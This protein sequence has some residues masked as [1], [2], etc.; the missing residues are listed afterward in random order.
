VFLVRC[1]DASLAEALHAT[2]EHEAFGEEWSA[3]FGEIMKP[4]HRHDVKL[5]L[6]APPVCEE[7]PTTL[8]PV[9][10]AS[11]S[12]SPNPN[13]NSNPTQPHPNQVRAA[14]ASL[15][16][17]LQ[18]ALTARLG[19]GSRLHEL[20]ALVSLPGAARQPVHPDTPMSSFE[21]V[22]EGE[23]KVSSSEC[24]TYQV[25]SST[26]HSLTARRGATSVNYA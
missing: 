3:R 24:A 14:L 12:A 17:A 10:N 7:A 5:G 18:P 11:A 25:L 8:A 2:R 23:A 22:G 15:L 16:G 6:E 13:P 1:V 21:E 20:A 26:G 9:L 4:C 19:E